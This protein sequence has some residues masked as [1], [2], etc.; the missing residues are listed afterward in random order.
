VEKRVVAARH[1][2]IDPKHVANAVRCAHRLSYSVLALF[3][4]WWLLA[5]VA[6]YRKQPENGERAPRIERKA[7]MDRI[8]E[9]A[10]NPQPQSASRVA[11]W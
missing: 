11:A 6:D 8:K 7:T 4:L 2:E 9:N 5:A 3:V 10:N 1:P